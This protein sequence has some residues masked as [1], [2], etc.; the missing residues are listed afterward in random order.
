MPQDNFQSVVSMEQPQSGNISA[1][2]DDN[3]SGDKTTT[4]TEVLYIY[5][6]ITYYSGSYWQEF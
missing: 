5:I 3:T 2:P 1:L 6:Y 4:V